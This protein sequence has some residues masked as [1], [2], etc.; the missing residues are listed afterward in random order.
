MFVRCLCEVEESSFSSTPEA[1]LS[2]SLFEIWH[3]ISK[4]IFKSSFQGETVEEM[5]CTNMN[6]NIEKALKSNRKYD[7]SKF[8]NAKE[9]LTQQNRI[10]D[11]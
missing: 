4:R 10:F 5:N 1:Q 2:S 11:E 8:L 9:G 7:V 3:T 6:A